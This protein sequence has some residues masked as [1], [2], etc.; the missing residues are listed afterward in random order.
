MILYVKNISGVSLKIELQP[1]SSVL[2]LKK[3]VQYASAEK[4]R[5]DA[6]GLDFGSQSLDN[7]R[8]I[9]DYN[10]QNETTLTLVSNILKLLLNSTEW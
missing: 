9:A 7:E 6:I 5:L 4:Y 10:L 1:G 3:K 2:D 8:M